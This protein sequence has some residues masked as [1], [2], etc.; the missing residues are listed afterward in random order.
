MRLSFRCEPAPAEPA[1][2]ATAAN[3]RV[4]RVLAAAFMLVVFAGCTGMFALSLTFDV[5]ADG[6]GTLV[7]FERSAEDGSEI[8]VVRIP[9]ELRR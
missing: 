4:M 2:A 5:D 7:A 8:H 3:L 6:K 9:V 1:P